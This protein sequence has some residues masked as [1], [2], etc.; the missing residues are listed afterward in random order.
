MRTVNATWIIRLLGIAALAS[1][2]ALGAGFEGTTVTKVLD[3]TGKDLKGEARQTF[4]LT[5]V[6]L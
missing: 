5:S 1:R 2:L 3:R 4:A 6:H